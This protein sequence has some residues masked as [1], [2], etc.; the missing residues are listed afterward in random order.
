KSL[1]CLVLAAI[2]AGSCSIPNLEAPDCIDARD[3]AREFYS[4]H[5]GSDLN[6]SP[7]RIAEQ[8][9][10]ISNAYADRLKNISADTDPFTMTPAS[11][12]PKAFRIGECRSLEPQKKVEFE[13]VFFWRTDTRSEQRSVAAETVNEDGRWV[14]DRVKAKQE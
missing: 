5:F 4:Q 7:E 2:F 12:P 13:V 14:I 11:D 3:T 8:K 10:F 9:R 1:F 6:F